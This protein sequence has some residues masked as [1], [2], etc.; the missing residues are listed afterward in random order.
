MEKTQKLLRKEIKRRR[1]EFEKI[2]IPNE[3]V[4]EI[5]VRL[6]VKSL[7]R[8]QS[9][10][11][12]WRT[13][14]T[15]KDFGE[16]HMALEKSKGCKLIFVC[17]D[18]EDRAEDTL[19]L[20]TVALEKTSASE[21]D[22]QAFEFQGFNGFLD[23]SESCDGLIC[24][25]DTKRAVEVMNPATTM[26]IQLPLSRIQRL[27][28]YKYPNSEVQDPNPVPDPIMSCSQ[29]G[30]GKDSVNGSYKLVWMYNTS[31]ATP[32]TCEVLDLE[33]KKWRF[34]NTNTLDHH[35]ILFNQRPVFAN[36]SLYWLTGDEQGYATTQTKLIVFDIHTEMFQV[37]QTPPFFTHDASG[38]KIGLCNLD[39]RLCISE[40]KKDCK[41]EF[42][43]RIE[44]T[45]TWERIFS[46]DLLSTSTWFGGI[47]WQPLTPL[48]ISRDT[49]KVIL[50]LRYQDNL[51]ALDLDPNSS[52]CHLY[53]S[54]YYGLVCPYFPSFVT[55]H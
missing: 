39:G 55:C 29:L 19:F 31:P 26:F 28:I 24:F 4:E 52:V 6:P 13:L 42:W 48:T 1:R 36:G 17:D 45:N 20:K 53:F 43:W 15:S 41:Q 23:I 50:S 11:K 49:N 18:F 46:V 16:R 35:K 32:P 2:H 10:S 44:D 30:F 14:I 22:E 5:M 54:G 21:G 25:Y 37:I 7:T 40:L 9:V 38:D 3:I 47:T 34:V 27:C 12:Y 8:F 51:V 33:G